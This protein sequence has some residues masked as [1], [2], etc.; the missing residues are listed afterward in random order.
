[1]TGT[2]ALASFLDLA[3]DGDDF[4]ADVLAG[5]AG[6]PKSISCKYFYDER[7]SDLFQR[8]CELPEYYLTRTE[9]ALL[10]DLA[11][12]A[13]GL[14]GPGCHLIEYGTGSSE[15]MRI[16]LDTLEH[17]ATFVAV[18]ISREHLLQATE[19]LA[20]DRPDLDV[21]AVCAD[22]TGPFEVP[23]AVAGAAGRR[24]VFFPGSSLGNFAPNE[25]TTFLAGAAHVAGPGGGLL[26]GVD[27]KKD[28]TILDAAYND[29]AGVTA[30][31]N[32]N[33]LVRINRELGGTF[34]VDTFRHH[35]FY[36]AEAGRIE[37]HL[38]SAKDQTAVV[39][40]QSFVFREGETIHT[41]NSYKYAS[42]NSMGWPPKPGSP[43]SRRGSTATAF[44]ASITWRLRTAPCVV[45]FG[46]YLGTV[47]KYA[48]IAGAGTA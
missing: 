40:G 11:T 24:V 39:S 4:L 12:E 27:L 34:D 23:D 33:L 45:E 6:D 2:L 8:I 43:R 31:F 5:L 44:S 14:I 1:M 19:A 28:Q 26:I 47:L 25:A 10:G 20:K 37:M 7:G 16:V 15:K 17:P 21:H 41:E 35:A 9:T 13:A 38:V 22:F 3:P 29:A 46:A 36:N 32:L 42:R 48:T 30:A 18:D